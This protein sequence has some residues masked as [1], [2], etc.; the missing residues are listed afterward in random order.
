MA[1]KDGFPTGADGKPRNLRAVD[2]TRVSLHELAELE[3]RVD[4][5]ESEAIWARW[6]MGRLLLPEREAHGGKQLPSGRMDDIVEATR[7]SAAEIRFRM[8]FAEQYPTEEKV[9]TA[10]E[11]LKTWTEIRRSFRRKPAGSRAVSRHAGSKAKWAVG[12]GDT[13]PDYDLDHDLEVDAEPRCSHLLEQ[14]T[15][16]L[17]DRLDAGTLDTHELEEIADALHRFKIEFA[18]ARAEL[19]GVAR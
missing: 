11:T 8:Q 19:S 5:G 1:A 17:D 15:A 14:A 18:R 4:A 2:P 7:K 13:K 10:V 12:N 9:S 16:V 3:A 6:K